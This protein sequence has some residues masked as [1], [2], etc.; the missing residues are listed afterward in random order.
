MKSISGSALPNR[1]GAAYRRDVPTAASRRPRAASTKEPR[2]AP[3]GKQ[4]KVSKAT[5][6]AVAAPALAPAARSFPQ[7][8]ARATYEALLEAARA[9]FA[10]RGYDAAQTPDIAQ[11]AGVSVGSFYR[12]FKDKRHVFVEMIGHHL[13]E[14]HG[15]VAAQLTA[16]RFRT[17]DPR[18]AID[19]ALEVLF[20]HVRR[21][22]ELHRV[23]LAMSMRDD[24]VA[25]LRARF[26]ALGEALIAGLV[27]ALVPRARI[28][29]AR[30][31][32]HVIQLAALE[33]ALG[34]AGLRGAGGRPRTDVAV[35]VALREMIHRYVFA[36]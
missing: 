35:R 29:D 32:A 16:D 1:G 13:A 11:R 18:Q 30:A 27:E 36:P 7:A 4:P 6:R 26:E 22:P 17:S 23:Y 25:A 21:Y 2:P 5:L 28:P 10:D 33:V 14:A 31:A 15:E 9:I 12:Y 24:D 34:Q 3:R 20:A 8:R 19:V